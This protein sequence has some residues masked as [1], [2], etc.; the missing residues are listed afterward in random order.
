MVVIW[1]GLAAALLVCVTI[2]RVIPHLQAATVGGTLPVLLAPAFLLLLVVGQLAGLAGV[3]FYG[4]HALF[5]TPVCTHRDPQPARA[6]VTSAVH[7][8]KPLGAVRECAPSPRAVVLPCV[9][10]YCG[11]RVETS[12]DAASRRTLRASS[13]A[14]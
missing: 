2:Q 11:V 7:M 8:K 14:G 4:W 9:G 3:C 1:G 12:S 6:P 10:R 13:P 5:T